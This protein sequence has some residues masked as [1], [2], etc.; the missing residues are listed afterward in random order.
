MWRFSVDDVHNTLESKLIKVE[1]VAHVIVGRH[2][3][4]VVIDHNRPISLLTNGVKC[5]HTT[6]VELHGTTYS[7]SSRAQNDDGITV[8]AE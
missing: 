5:L 7:V 6:P 8:V 1:T 3:F 4:R 2:R